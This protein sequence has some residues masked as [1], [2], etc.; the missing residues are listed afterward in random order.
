MNSSLNSFLVLSK[1]HA[2]Y[3]KVCCNFSKKLY[4]KLYTNYTL[5]T[6]I[7]TLRVLIV[8]GDFH[9]YNKHVTF[10]LGNNIIIL[11]VSLSS[12]CVSLKVLPS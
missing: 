7:N 11:N 2:N 8:T 6:F 1:T 10:R 3:Q 4:T 12:S 5:T 9:S